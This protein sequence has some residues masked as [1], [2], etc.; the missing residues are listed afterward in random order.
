LLAVDRQP[1]PDGAALAD[2]LA[3]RSDGALPLLLMRGSVLEDLVV[4]PVTAAR[5]A[6]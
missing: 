2:A 6:A 4:A 5:K 3:Q 1:T